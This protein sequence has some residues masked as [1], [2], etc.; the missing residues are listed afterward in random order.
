MG[1]RYLAGTGPWRRAA[2]PLSG[3]VALLAAFLAVGHTQAGGWALDL[4]SATGP[5]PW[6][7]R[8]LAFWTLFGGASAL[9]LAIGAWRA[10]AA[11]HADRRFL[12]AWRRVPDSRW[13]L[14]GSIAAFALP[15][16]LR[17]RLLLDAALVDDENAYRFAA[18]ILAEGRLFLDSPPMKL[19][20]DNPFLINDGRLYTQY[21][22]GWPALMVPALLLGVPGLA[23]AF[24]SA[25][26]V[27]ALFGVVRRLAGSDWAKAA[28]AL[29]LASPMLMVG[30]A[31]ETSHTSCVAALLWSVWF[32]LRVREPQA[33]EWAHA[34]LAF[35]FSAAFFIRPTA[36]L[37]IG[38]PILVAWLGGLRALAGAERRR[39]LAA[40]A[41]PAAAMAALFLGVNQA[42]NGSLLGV[43]Y[44]RYYEYAGANGFRFSVWQGETEAPVR[45]FRFDEPTRALGVV[46][47]A[48]F[49][50][51]AAFF[52]WPSS[53]VFV[54]FARG[55]RA[56]L[57]WWSAASFLALHFFTQ[58]V[59]VDTFAPM[60]FYELALPALALTA[61][62]LR[63]LASTLDGW[64]AGAA[65]LAPLCAAALVA[66][67]LVGYVPVRF[68]AIHQMA[69][70]AATPYE[71]LG[72]A[73]IERGVVFAPTPFIPRCK[74]TP[75]AAFRFSRPNNDPGLSND[76]L[77]VN[78]LSIE[79]DKEL[80][81]DVFPDR[82]GWV[83]GWSNDCRAVFLPLAELGPA[84][85]PPSRELAPQSR[86]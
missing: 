67:T 48:L 21:F 74:Y 86:P 76:V 44:Q 79:L 40:F 62:G 7:G 82:Q 55:R 60:H 14:Y 33:P 46:G 49:R 5:T 37:G 56:R 28:V 69:R 84:S 78:H 23:N 50:F 85:V 19:F 8:F 10:L 32:F 72:E 70:A 75:S 47:L 58:E 65:W 16:M 54:V 39:A 63:N 4:G 30:A 3:G 42:Q 68:A 35:M 9:L 71:A 73:G 64:R 12:A 2:V 29:Y 45:N 17:A 13:V 43:G 51:Q 80:M 61:L 57:F 77:W 81:T 59:G 11:T 83:M 18:A 34:G 31:T 20:F 22:L 6:Y 38:I 24:Y 52:G 1:R 15:A 41:L 27:P 36:A 53:L 66:V 26:T 25:A